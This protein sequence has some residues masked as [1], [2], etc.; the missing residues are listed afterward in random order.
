[1]QYATLC[2]TYNAIESTPKRLEKTAHISALL[3]RTSEQDL[4]RVVV[5]LQGKVFSAVDKQTLGISSRLTLKALARVTGAST[6]ELEKEWSRTGD[7]G[8]VAQTLVSTKSQQ[9]LFT[10]H[11]SVEHVHT[12]LVRLAHTEGKNSVDTK[13]KIL[14]ELLSNASAQ[15]A[16]Y[17][18]RTVLEELRIGIATQTLRD[19]ITY[20][21]LAE[22][23]GIENG[24]I[25]DRD[26]YNTVTAIIQS[27]YDK[28]NDFTKVA[29]K[30]IKGL[31]ALKDVHLTVGQPLKVMLGVRGTLTDAFENFSLPLLVQYKYDGFRVQIHKHEDKIT[32]YTRRLENVTEQFP[33]IVERARSC[34][35]ARTAII[36]AEAIGIDPDT[37]RYKPFQE[38]SQRIRRKYG[39]DEMAEKLPVDVRCFD[40]MLAEDTEY[41]ED[42]LKKR[43][44][45]LQAIINEHELFGIAHTLITENETQANAFYDDAIAAGEEGIFAKHLQSTYQPGVRV[46]NWMK[47]KHTMEPVDVVIIS[48][49][50]GEGKRSGWLTSFTIAVQDESGVLQ[51][52]GKVATGLKER[53]EEGFSFKEITEL[54]A[55]LIEFEDG[56]Y[57][58]VKPEIV[59]E[60]AY[61]EIQQSPTYSSGYALRFPRIL[62]NRSEDKTVDDITTT[63]YLTLLYE[64][65]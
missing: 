56:R 14:S 37:K 19:A 8:L 5:L 53:E 12:Q 44:E 11:L 1:M 38:I 16:K 62:R 20:A 41:L 25:V 6:Q 65:Q 40:V 61:D 46:G 4:A 24:D 63:D 49:E 28:T 45:Q 59:V 15:E 43:H 48:A 54:L 50:W 39:I 35:R 9:T 18:V 10:Q 57:V 42:P 7:L 31:K 29:Q 51:E 36:D 17:L 27:A 32:I 52:I 47:I 30:A 3:K 60:V 21:Y 58:R 34:I 33:D 55:P 22:H 13:L 64:A 26:A 23:A 2:E